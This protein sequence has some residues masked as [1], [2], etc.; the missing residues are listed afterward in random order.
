MSDTIDHAAAVAVPTEEP[1]EVIHLFKSKPEMMGYAFKNGKVVHFMNHNYFTAD[2]DE[3]AELTKECKTSTTFYID[4][5]NKTV[6]DV[7]A[8]N[9]P[10]AGIKQRI[11]EEERLKLMEEMGMSRDMGKSENKGLGQIANSMSIRG[12]S[13][14]SN[15]VPASSGIK[16]GGGASASRVS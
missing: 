5:E 14:N 7:A 8:F 1:K 11:R 2:A 4:A 12:A 6:A 9:D 15:S 16:V 10:L 3:I 13:Q